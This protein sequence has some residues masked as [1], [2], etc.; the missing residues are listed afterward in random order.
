M[1]SHVAKIAHAKK[2]VHFVHRIL[3]FHFF[4]ILI[5]AHGST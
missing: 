1:Y 4:P 5:F 3:D 2:E